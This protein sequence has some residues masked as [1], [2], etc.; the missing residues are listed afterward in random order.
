MPSTDLGLPYPT[1]SEPPN[2][3]GAIG[4]LA[5]ATNDLLETL[6][7]SWTSYTP[8]WNTT[9]GSPTLGSATL[10]GAQ[11]T[12]GKTVD[13]QIVLTWGAGTS[14]PSGG[15]SFAVPV[16]P[17][18]RSVFFGEVYDASAT[19]HWTASFEVDAGATTGSILVGPST[20]GNAWRAVGSTTP[21]TWASGDIVALSGSYETA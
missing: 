15:W 14:V 9:G 4:A 6:F 16:A 18:R 11:R 7:G 3:P 5:Q 1:G 12:V 8:T 21:F 2:G 20:A 10:V 19:S 13:F 17:L